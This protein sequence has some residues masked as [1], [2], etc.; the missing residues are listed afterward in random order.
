MMNNSSHLSS[1]L[2][3]LYE[4]SF[5]DIEE[6]QIIKAKIVQVRGNE[7]I[8][9]VGYKAEGIIS[10]DEFL[11]PA[12][13]EVGKEIDVYV[14][15]KENDEGLVVLSKRIADKILGW[16]RISKEC[17]IGDIVEGKVVKKVKG[18]LIVNIGV[19]AF[20]PASLLELKSAPNLDSYIGQKVKC[21]IVNINSKRKNVVISRRDVL[22]KEMEEEKKRFLDSLKRG[23]KVE[24]IVK[25][26]TD[27]GAFIELGPIDGLLHISDMSWG[28][29]SHPSEL[30]AVGDKLELVVLDVDKKNERVSLGLKQKTP[31][32]W[33][34]IDKRYPAGSKLKGKVVNI[35]PHGAFVAIEEGVEGFV[36]V[37]DLSWTRRVKDPHEVLAIGDLIEA[38]VLSIDRARRRLNLGIKQLEK[39]PWQ[40]IED[41]YPLDS[42]VEGRIIGFSDFGVYVELDQGIEGFL[43]KNDISW[44]RKVNY[45]S[46]IFKKGQR[47]KFK[48]IGINKLGRRII[49]GL[50]QLIPDPWQRIQERYKPGMEIEGKVVSIVPFG[51]F[52]ELEPDLEGLLHISELESPTTN[53]QE[54]F[55]P[56]DKI[57]VKV[58]T[59]DRKKRQIKLTRR[60]ISQV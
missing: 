1:E 23:D 12:D 60:G 25:N 5:R 53:L 45:P 28:R 37:S 26:I 40:D 19:E 11:D 41:R 31:D 58:L 35:I 6:G 15:S 10:R 18:G 55:S 56:G 9:D 3:K 21:M 42:V 38:I 2:D 32:P 13:I 33:I 8:L 44:T 43:S 51:I 30:L 54:R 52:V 4:E 57:K 36:H 50:K 14:E 59:I 34:D 16:E 22:L 47:L 27:Y 17:K 49:L 39:D 46:E 24:G 29:I 7:V 20:L 48:V